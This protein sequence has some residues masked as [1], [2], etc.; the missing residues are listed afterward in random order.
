MYTQPSALTART[1][2]ALTQPAFRI[3]EKENEEKE[4]NQED[5]LE[6]CLKE[7]LVS[8]CREVCATKSPANWFGLCD[9]PPAEAVQVGAAGWILALCWTLCQQNSA[10]Q[11][12]S[13]DRQPS[14]PPAGFGSTLGN[15]HIFPMRIK[16]KCS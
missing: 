4:N 15:N 14:L 3:K 8:Q 13:G 5:Q 2:N 16:L 6:L 1:D 7:L 10:C 9:K 12:D 11:G